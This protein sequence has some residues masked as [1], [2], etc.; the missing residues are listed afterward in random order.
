MARKLRVEYL[1][2][3]YH[4][5]NR[6]DRGKPIFRD[7]ED[8]Q[9]FIDTLSEACAK[10]G[11]QVHALCLMG[12]HFHLIIETPQSNLCFVVNCCFQAYLDALR[13]ACPVALG[14]GFWR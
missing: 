1:G 14:G 10:T 7:A 4:V 5:M 6:G 11:W 3:F 13:D 8:R 12:N 2:A 9:A